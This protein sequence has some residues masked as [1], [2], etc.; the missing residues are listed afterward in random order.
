MTRYL[1]D[2][3]VL[4][5]LSKRIEPVVHAFDELVAAGDGVGVCS[6]AVAEFFAGLPSDQRPKWERFIESLRFWS[7]TERSAIRAG[8]YRFDLAR[9]GRT[10]ST[11]DALIAAIAV[12]AGAIIA[13]ENVKDFP[14]PDVRVVSLRASGS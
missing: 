10:I 13:T 2:T 9:Q 3:S 11:T 5:D 14:M 6:V 4:V 8:V 12:E 1:L 7:A